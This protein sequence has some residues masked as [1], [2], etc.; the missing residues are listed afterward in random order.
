MGLVDYSSSSE[1][2]SE[3]QPQ[4]AVAGPQ[5]AAPA[6][7]PAK[8]PAVEKLRG[9]D[10]KIRVT[11]NE[12]KDVVAP[13]DRP[14]K[15]IK[16]EGG[17]FSGFNSFLPPPK[18][19]G[20]PTNFTGGSAAKGTSAA[21]PRPG[22]HLKTGAAPGFS[23]AVDGGGLNAALGE[24]GSEGKVTDGPVIP[25]GMKPEEEVKFVG[26]PLM[27]KPLSV[28]RKMG[29]KKGAQAGAKTGHASTSTATTP[30]LPAET[31]ATPRAQPERAPPPK[32]VS[33]FSLPTEEEPTTES[34]TSTYE[35]ETINP[36]PA[37]LAA[38]AAAAQPTA[39]SP[40]PAVEAP[41][42]DSI[43]N[44]LN[45]S[46]AARREL[47]GRGGAKASAAQ[48]RTFDLDAEYRANEEWRASG[49]AEQQQVHRPVSGLNASGKTNL[50]QLVNHVTSQR[51]ALEESFSSGKTKRKEA[52]GRYG[53]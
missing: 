24:G 53:W 4:S 20:K 23:R 43:A 41:S 29:K 18:N 21:A 48:V 5:S 37:Y 9:A 31:Q 32:T 28:A 2:E 16:T 7:Q 25:E 6:R 3:P 40:E 12:T 11:L 45:L 34:T 39:P 42:L 17:V 51:D 15:R 38:A 52:G 49:A 46:A 8:K 1:S 10:G 33:L 36:Q 26:K 50:R 22:V 44:D 13:S 27:F 14:A 30:K 47:F 35:Y 19:T